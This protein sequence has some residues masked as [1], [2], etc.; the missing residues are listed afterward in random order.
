M[1]RRG[2]LLMFT[3]LFSIETGPKDENGKKISKGKKD[4]QYYC[5]KIFRIFAT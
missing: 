3:A 4:R 1:S 2:Y 5:T